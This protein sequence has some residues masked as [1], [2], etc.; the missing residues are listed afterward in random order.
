M[1]HLPV[2][3]SRIALAGAL[4]IGGFAAPAAAQDVSSDE[5]ATGLTDAD[6]GAIVVTAR[7]REEN[8]LDVP[9]AVTAYGAEALE[10]SGSLDLTDIGD[11]TPNVTI[12]NSR[13]TN[14]TLSA[15]IRG[16]GQQDPVGG[17]ESGVGIYLDDV[18]LNRP[19][20][21]VLDIYDVERIEV[22]RGPQGTL[23]GR[24]TI[25]G[26]IKYVSR[27][28]PDDVEVKL[29]ATYGS[30]DQADAVVSVAV[31]LGDMFKFGASGARLSRGGFGDN[32]NLGI[33][34]YNKDVWAG[35]A[36][37]EFESPDNRLFVR[38]SGDY[39]HDKSNPRNGH[40]LLPGALSGA[41]VLDNVYDTRAG[42]TVP[43]QDI[44]AYGLMMNVTAELSDNFTLR[45]I[46]AWRED[47][48][49]VP[50]DF[51]SLPTVDVDVPGIYFNDQTSQEFQLLYNSDRLNGLVGFYYLEANA[52][53]QFDVILA[54]TGPL[55]GVPL[56]SSFGQF[57]SGDVNTETWSAFGDFTF[58]VTDWLSVSGGLRY[59]KDDRRSIIL[60][61]NRLNLPSPQFGGNG[62]NLGPAITDFTGKASFEKWT[63][64]VSVSVKPT[65]DLLVYASYSQGFKGGGFDPRGSA[66]T[67]PNTDGVAGP[68]SYAEIYDFFLFEPETV[69]SYEVGVK[70]SLFDRALT[71]ALTGFYADYTNVQIPGSVGVDANGDGI[72]EGFAGVTTNAGKARFKG[73]EAEVFARIA[74]DFAGP[75]SRITLAGTAGY[76]DAKYLEYVAIIAGVETNLAP[77]RGIQNTPK[78]TASATLGADMPVGAG[79]LSANLTVSH[80]S[81]T[82]QF[83]IANPYLDQE[84]YQLLDAGVTY[85]WG[86][87][88]FSL[89]VYGKNLTNERYITSGYPFIA[90]NAVTGV[91]VLNNGNPVPALGREGTLT[92]FYGNPRQVFVTGTVKF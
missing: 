4:L 50:I 56:A 25:G 54:T 68:P 75:G 12:E 46:S 71:Y 38:I 23:Y 45:S 82:Q 53:T 7:R 35:R 14:S 26:A 47:K 9:I 72:F 77:F 90:T 31:P 43:E 85:R 70:G 32:L 2:R 18:Y 86:G 65:E 49:Y 3:A 58:D 73:V 62:F 66:N 16:V 60:K 55:I 84:G 19:Q 52:L 88:R 69:D 24:N 30:Y 34:N 40:R 67:T 48:S 91:P 10:E 29:R 51:D 80:R 63:P 83:E 41:P 1:I 21:A 92:A 20:A 81:S 15:F 89:G 59:T 87:D 36:S 42:L 64:R 5:A 13:A 28:L 33:E 79:D 39:T 61:A 57:T 37:V 27:R 6:D 78:F 17:F 44:K 8:L 11:T 74:Q 22:L 76:I